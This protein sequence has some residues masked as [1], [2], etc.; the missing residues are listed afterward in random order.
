MSYFDYQFLVASL[1][2]KRKR[3]SGKS[4][5]RKL[6]PVQKSAIEKAKRLRKM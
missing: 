5:P 1:G 2:E 3:K 4:T 6:L